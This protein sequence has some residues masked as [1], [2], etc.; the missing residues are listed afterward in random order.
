MRSEV[1]DTALAVDLGKAAM[2]FAAE[3]GGSTERK[4]KSLPAPAG[5]QTFFLYIRAQGHVPEHTVSGPITIQN[6]FGR[7]SIT[8]AGHNHDLEEGQMVALAAGIPHGV[9][10]TRETVLLVTHALRD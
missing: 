9:L 4:K 8:A 3:V 5:L 7:A 1:F 6:I 2:D 10:A